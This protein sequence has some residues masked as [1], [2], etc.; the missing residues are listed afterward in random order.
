MP[1]L[2][3]SRGLEKRDLAP[4]GR[5]IMISFV[6]VDVQEASRLRTHPA[7]TWGTWEGFLET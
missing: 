5:V 2:A 7:L 3:T 6:M 4:H 1:A